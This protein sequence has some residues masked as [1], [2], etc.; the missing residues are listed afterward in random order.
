MRI[1]TL[2]AICAALLLLPVKQAG[3]GDVESRVKA[4]YIYNFTKFIQWPDEDASTT[5]PIMICVAGSDPIRTVLGELSNREAKG[6]MLKIVRVTELDALPHCNILFISRS[7]EHQLPLILQKTQGSHF[8][9]VSD[10][11]RFASRGGMIGFTPEKDRLKMEINQRNT[12]QAGLKVSA[13][14]LEVARIIP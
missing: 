13:K 2:L 3:A 8:L 11:P 12:A 10:I 1:F 6:R 4:A 9:T 7:E 14:L 5:T